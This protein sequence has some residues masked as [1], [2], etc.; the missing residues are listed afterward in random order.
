MKKYVIIVAGGE[1]KRMGGN[2]PKQFL[3]LHGKPILY[4]TIK[5]FLDSDDDVQLIVVLPE[6]YIGAGQEIIDG[7]FS[8]DRISLCAGGRTRFHSVQNGLK[9][10]SEESIILVH[11]AVRC[12]LSKA[13]IK[14]VYKAALQ[15]GTAV[16]VIDCAD[17]V[18][19]IGEEGSEAF[20]RE[21]IKLV[22]TPQGFHSKIL[23]P[24]YA[25]DYKPHFTDEASVVEAYGLKIQ[26][27]QGETNNIKITLPLHLLLAA[28]LLDPKL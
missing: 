12:T 15:N 24:A 26:L 18:R 16:P 8:Y 9:L 5:V 25:I 11:D 3:M 17:S 20:D 1:G 10:I 28:G 7:Y 21:K 19:I 2:L 23:I 13:L 6:E 22:Q 14:S 4:H 27:V